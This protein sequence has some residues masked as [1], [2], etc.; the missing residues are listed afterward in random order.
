VI[1]TLRAVSTLH[2][3]R[4]RERACFRPR[5]AEGDV[6]YFSGDTNF[7]ARSYPTIDEVDF[8]ECREPDYT[9]TV[10]L[11]ANFAHLLDDMDRPGDARFNVGKIVDWEE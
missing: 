10:T 3:Q 2:D 11:F 9:F 1:R 5:L 7:D 8:S 4:I 6:G